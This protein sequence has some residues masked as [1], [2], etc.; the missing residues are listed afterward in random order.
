MDGGATERLYT[1]LHPHTMVRL[2]RDRDMTKRI[3]LLEALASTIADLD[4]LVR[5]VDE[6][7]S[8]WQPPAMPRSQRD[9]VA[10]LVHTERAFRQD[11]ML[12]LREDWP[13]IAA[14]P[15]E[16]NSHPTRES[17]DALAAQFAFERKQT[18]ELLREL[19]PGQWQRCAIHAEKG[20]LTLR[21]LVQELVDHDIEHTSEL[22]MIQSAR[23][24][25]LKAAAA[26]HLELS[27]ESEKQ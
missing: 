13:T 17:L 4:R 24:R 16:D 11:M 25:A 9:V 2:S 22:V 19:G 27:L 14:H 5:D 1:A 20:R 15:S 3:V 7:T 6:A 10:H 26:A 21:F 18:L 23:R 8:A 12:V